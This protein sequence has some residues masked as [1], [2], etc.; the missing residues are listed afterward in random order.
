LTD[1]RSRLYVEVDKFKA[2]AEA[3]YPTEPRYGEWECDYPTWDD[4]YTAYVGFLDAFSPTEWDRTDTDAI[5]YGLARDNEA[6][7]LQFELEQRPQSLTALARYALST[8]CDYHARWQLADAL[9]T[10]EPSVSEGLLQAYFRDSHEYVRRIALLSLGRIGSRS[11]ERLAPEAWAT[12]DQYQ[13]ICALS[14][15][16][17]IGSE[18]LPK[19]IAMAME[20]GRD[21]LVWNVKRILSGE[22]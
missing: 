18:M 9:K 22:Q 7:K 12:G 19:Y 20:D 8:P 11:V 1:E 3:E 16:A 2:W 10:V 17:D 4:L 15:L 14:A 5:L 13:R 6:Q 21:H